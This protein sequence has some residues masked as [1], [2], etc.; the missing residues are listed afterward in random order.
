MG[1]YLLSFWN[2][3]VSLDFPTVESPEKFRTKKRRTHVIDD[4]NVQALSATNDMDMRENL[5]Q[6]SSSQEPE[7][8]RNIPSDSNGPSFDTPR[9]PWHSRAASS[10]K[11]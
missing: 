4:A 7:F 5:V 6:E 2:S 8:F 11:I 1:P 10:G 3:S 9:L